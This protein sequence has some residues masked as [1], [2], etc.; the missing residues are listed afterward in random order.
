MRPT[1]ARPRSRAR[2]ADRGNRGRAAPRRAAAD[3]ARRG[4][5]RSVAANLTAPDGRVGYDL[6][7]MSDQPT[8][9]AEALIRA[10]HLTKTFGSFTAVD[11][12]DFEVAPGESFGFLGPNGAGKTPTMRMIGRV[13][14]ISDGELSV[15][16]RRPRTHGA[17]IRRRTGVAPQQDRRDTELPA[18]ETLVI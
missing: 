17:P 3:R 10:R 8:S 15:P 2:R 9:A 5:L 7:P 1:A 11:A 14:P 18:R 12:I 16:G 13:S 4:E 6:V